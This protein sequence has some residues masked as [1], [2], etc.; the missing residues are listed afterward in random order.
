MSAGL[1]IAILVVHG[2][3][4]KGGVVT[5]LVSRSAVFACVLALTS[6]VYAQERSLAQPGAV[7]SREFINQMAIAGLAEVQLGKIAAEH[8]SNPDVKAFG[9]MMM[10]D[11]SQANKEL[12]QIASQVNVTMPTQLD[13]KHQDLAAKLSKLHGADF[14]REYITAM[15]EGHSEV[16]SKLQAWTG[17]RTAATD[18][19]KPS[20]GAAVGTAGGDKGEQALKQW[21][22]KALPTVQKHLNRAQ[23]LQQKIK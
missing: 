12:A 19:A 1:A 6:A 5:R 8:A 9:Q 11:H 15:V 2:V 20:T 23:E 16:V 18:P 13:K 10:R 17:N 14:D 21:A 4:R 7:D 3:H 22:T